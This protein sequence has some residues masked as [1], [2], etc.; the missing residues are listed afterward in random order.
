MAVAVVTVVSSDGEGDSEGR[1]AEGATDGE[2]EQRQQL[3]I[4]GGWTGR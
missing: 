2:G 3:G 1:R 4:R